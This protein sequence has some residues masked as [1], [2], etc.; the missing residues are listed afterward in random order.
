MRRSVD[1]R[2]VPAPGHP[3]RSGRARASV[4]WASPSVRAWGRSVVIPL[5]LGLICLRSLVHVGYLLQLDVVFGPRPAPL[6]LGFGTPV[7]L[8]QNAGVELLGGALTGRLYALATVFLAGFAPM[9]LLRRQPWF[10]QTAGGVV[11]MLNPFVYERLVEGQWDVVNAASALFL[12][13]AAWEGLQTRP[14]PRPALLLAFCTVLVGAFDAHALGPVLVLTVVAV[15]WQRLWRRRA[16]VVWTAA[17]FAIAAVVFS[18]PAVA[19]FVDNRAG[20]AAVQ[21]FTRA[22][23]E[24]FRSVSSGDYGLIP[25]LVGLY[26]YWGE[27]IGRFPVASQDA[28]WWPATTALLV[29]AALAGAWLC[30]ARAWLLVCGVV[31]LAASAST[32]LPGGVDAATWLAQRLPLVAAYREPQKWSALWLVALVTLSAGAAG[33]LGKRQ[34]PG[35]WAGPALAYALVMCALFPAGLAQIRNAPSIVKPLR[36]PAY[37]SR[38]ARFLDRTVPAD[39][40]IVVLPWHLYQPLVP[41]EGR[42]VANP[43]SVFFPGR[44][45]VPHNLEI[46]GRFSEVTSPYD[47]IGSVIER[48]GYR[49]CAAARAIRRAGVRWALVLDGAEAGEI[50]RAFRDCGFGLVQGFPGRTAVLRS[51]PGVSGFTSARGG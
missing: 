49:S 19:F 20:Y 21:Q 35:A 28:P 5:G 36:Y 23:F 12:W 38:T 22:D 45:V 4:A 31:G 37:W 42:T 41:S 46:P 8:L 1:G 24:F 25:N 44:L 32:A 9:V 11:G 29:G 27:R 16:A 33:A 51:A 30:R 15:L 34:R 6:T 2:A 43:A 50:V 26:G 7:A 3:L 48:R 39:E 10:A 47:R 40:R 17:S 13:I 18:Y 14:G